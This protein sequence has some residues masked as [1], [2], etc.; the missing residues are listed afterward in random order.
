MWAR[1]RCTG[2]SIHFALRGASEVPIAVADGL[3]LYPGGFGGADIVHRVHPEGVEDYVVFESRPPT[4]RLVYDVDVSA[5]AGLRLVADTLELLDG[6]GAP[7]LRVAPPY[8]VD[9]MGRRHAAKLEL[10]VGRGLRAGSAVRAGDW[11]VRDHWSDLRRPLHG[12]AAERSG[13]VVRA[14]QV[15]GRS[16]HGLVHDRERLRA[17]PRLR[18]N[19][20][21]AGERIRGRG[22]H[23]RHG[24]KQRRGAGGLRRGRRRHRCGRGLG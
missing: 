21:R 9:A 19:E 12:Q 13:A 8:V 1:R 18:G 23:G 5:V 4:E 17:G 24:R 2:L 14:V 11:Q 15:R 6:G 16:V 3:V 7:R 22:R 10:R 20:V